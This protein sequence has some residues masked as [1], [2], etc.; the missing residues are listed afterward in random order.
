M[1]FSS[2][3]LLFFKMLSFNKTVID[4]LFFFFRRIWIHGKPLKKR[5]LTFFL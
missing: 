3:S 4:I 1:N 5:L 2:F